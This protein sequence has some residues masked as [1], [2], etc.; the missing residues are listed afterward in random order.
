MVRPDRDAGLRLVAVHIDRVRTMFF[1]QG[2]PRFLFVPLAEAVI[3][4]IA[5]S[6][7]LSRTLVPTM[8][9]Y[10]LHPHKPASQ[11]DS[12]SRSRNPLVRFQRAFETRFERIR[13]SYR[14]L[15]AVLIARR[16]VFCRCFSSAARCPFCCCR[17]LGVI[18]SPRWTRDRS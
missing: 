8:A 2:V 16:M 3:F 10:M 5:W 12:A 15:L 18:S 1:L 6:F 9:K 17:F 4:S 7:L 14:A 13:Q 11:D